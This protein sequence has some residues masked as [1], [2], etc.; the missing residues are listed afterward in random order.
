MN[1]I[2]VETWDNFKV[3]AGNIIRDSFVQT[4]LPLF[5]PTDITKNNQ[6][7]A[8]S[9]QVFYGAKYEEINEISC[10]TVALIGVQVNITDDNMAVIRSKVSQELSRNI[11]L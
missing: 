7:C 10:R 4:N 2:L 9:I 6:A 1:P 11:V 3:S 5:I 8:A